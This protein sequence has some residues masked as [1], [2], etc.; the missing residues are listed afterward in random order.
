M[1]NVERYISELID[2]LKVKFDSRLLYV[3]LQ[4][5]YLRGEA[6]LEPG[7]NSQFGLN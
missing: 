3:G 4:G 1:I 6:M 5:S 2:L 7:G